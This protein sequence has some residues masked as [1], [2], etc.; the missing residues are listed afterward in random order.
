[1]GGAGSLL[2]HAGGLALGFVGSSCGFRAADGPELP[3]HA[4]RIK[5]YGVV[6]EVDAPEAQ[7]FCASN[8]CDLLVPP[9]THGIR[10]RYHEVTR[11]SGIVWTKRSREAQPIELTLRPDTVYSLLAPPCPGAPGWF[12]RV[13]VDGGPRAGELV[14]SNQD[15]R[16]PAPSGAASTGE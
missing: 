1:M 12:V 14:L 3:P 10:V 13:T 16:C 7:R 5:S 2:R 11:G 15:E 4:A 6:L 8:V 9:G